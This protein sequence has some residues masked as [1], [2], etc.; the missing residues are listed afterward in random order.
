MKGLNTLERSISETAQVTKITE[1]SEVMILD[2]F[3][4]DIEAKAL[5]TK[6]VFTDNWVNAVDGNVQFVPM[7][8][9]TRHFMADK[10]NS[11]ESPF[12]EEIDLEEMLKTA[13]V[14]SLHVPL[15]AETKGMINTELITKM[16]DGV[17]LLNT[18]RGGIC[19]LADVQF[20][21]IGGKIKSFGTDVLEN[22]NL[23][24]WTE[25]E[26]RLVEA[27]VSSNQVLITP[28]VAGWTFESYQKIADVL[29][30]KIIEYTTKLK[31]I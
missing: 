29:A 30:H 8:L 11:I 26:R 14:I 6:I 9:E 1:E 13:D 24:A 23:S 3:S 12:A 10:Y 18:S 20:G 22:E 19:K 5:I 2:E 16:K 28:H 15:T 7:T 21:I 27:L 4:E 31:N 17:V 25:E